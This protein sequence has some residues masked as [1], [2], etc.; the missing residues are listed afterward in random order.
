M[1][2]KHE[3]TLDSLKEEAAG[4][5]WRICITRRMCSDMK[6]D[7]EDLDQFIGEEMRRSMDEIDNMSF[8]KFAQ[9]ILNDLIAMETGE[10]DWLSVPSSP[11]EN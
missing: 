8:G 2:N 1:N 11:K 9:M 10:G 6:F 5:I 4:Y 3:L 7:T